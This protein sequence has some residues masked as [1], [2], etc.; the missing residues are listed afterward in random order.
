LPT[1]PRTSRC[2]WSNALWAAPPRIVLLHL[3]DPNRPER[4]ALAAELNSA[5]LWGSADSFSDVI[6]FV[7]LAE[8]GKSCSFAG[9]TLSD[10]AD[11][12][13]IVR[14]L[15]GASQHGGRKES[16]MV[17]Q[18]QLFL[19]P[20]LHAHWTVIATEPSS[21]AMARSRSSARYLSNDRAV[22][23]AVALLSVARFAAR[24]G[25]GP[26][27]IR[28]AAPGRR[29]LCHRVTIAGTTSSGSWR[30]RSTTWR[31]AWAWQLDT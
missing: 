31:P 13:G 25:A 14:R 15:S 23:A 29:R 2:W 28:N 8:T 22:A 21:A 5:Q 12:A 17:G 24:W 19:K 7:V 4:F 1:W 16:I 3:I 6:G 20:V 26:K 9:R 11:A 30:P 10:P 18:W 27:L